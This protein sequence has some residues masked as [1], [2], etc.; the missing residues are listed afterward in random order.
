M[1]PTRSHGLVNI[2]WLLCFHCLGGEI[3]HSLYFLVYL[4]HLKWVKPQS[5][6]CTLREY[7]IRDLL[8]Q[9]KVHVISYLISD[10]KGRVGEQG[11]TSMWSSCYWVCMENLMWGAH[12]SSPHAR[13][14]WSQ[15]AL[16]LKAPV[17]VFFTYNPISSKFCSCS[18]PF[19]N[20][21][22]WAF[23]SLEA[24]ESCW[25]TSAG[26]WAF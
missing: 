6:W 14:R 25:K 21:E 24:S 26:P 18:R 11:Y 17:S 16:C 20:P 5:I 23:W 10:A 12:P 1:N 22:L 9:T 19:L 4:L 13:L 15:L 2:L 8:S 3:C 7:M